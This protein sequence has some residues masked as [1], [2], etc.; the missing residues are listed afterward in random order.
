M[1]VDHN[2]MA[3]R[4]TAANAIVSLIPAEHAAVRATD[5][6]GGH[7]MARY[8]RLSQHMGDTAHALMHGNEPLEDRLAHIAATAMAWIDQIMQ[9]RAA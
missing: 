2:I 3:R 9:E 1:T 6:I 8:A 7:D 4:V 5:D